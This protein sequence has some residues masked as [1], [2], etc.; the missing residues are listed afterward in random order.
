MSKMGEAKELRASCLTYS[1]LR[2]L[3][4]ARNSTEGSA[5]PSLLLSDT[6]GSLV[7][8]KDLHTDLVHNL[9][10]H[11]AFFLSS[12]AFKNCSLIESMGMM[13][14]RKCALHAEILK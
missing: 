2:V 13:K 10:C 7:V 11:G 4:S 3:L 14:S 12:V 1:E 6:Q 9:K 8:G 5:Q